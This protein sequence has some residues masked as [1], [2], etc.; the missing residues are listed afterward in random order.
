MNAF[1]VIRNHQGTC[2]FRQLKKGD[3]LAVPGK[4]EGIKYF[5]HVIFI[6]LE[7]GVIDFGGADKETAEVRFVDLF[8]F[9]HDPYQV[10]R[11]IYP[12]GRCLEPDEVERR[13]KLLKKNPESYPDYNALTNNCEHFA[14]YC[15]M[16]VGISLQAIGVFAESIAKLLS[17]AIDNASSFGSLSANSS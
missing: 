2:I 8:E 7:E 3:H 16:G 12:H 15:K 13:A 14:T 17:L 10:F 9:V 6:S 4:R 1:N 11:V 5:H